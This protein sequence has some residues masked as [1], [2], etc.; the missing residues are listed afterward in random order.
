[1]EELRTL[2]KLLEEGFLT[3]EE[4]DKRRVEAVDKMLG[5]TSVKEKNSSKEKISPP[6]KEKSSPPSGLFLFFFFFFLRFLI[7]SQI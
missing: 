5:N 2:K 3:Q 7:S 6:S 1:M 4:Y